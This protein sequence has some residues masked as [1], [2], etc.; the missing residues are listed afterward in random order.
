MPGLGME[1]R[2]AA[3]L[4]GKRRAAA[5]TSCPGLGSGQTRFWSAG[6]VD[7]AA[8]LGERS[9]TIESAALTCDQLATLILRH[10]AGANGAIGLA[11][12][13]R[14][15]ETG[16]SGDHKLAQFLIECEKRNWIIWG[17]KHRR[18]LGFVDLLIFTG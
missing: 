16:Y 9:L 15:F 3:V 10:G 17:G 18:S 2:G 12:I 7:V 4:V 14:D 13:S 6:L 8:R 5:Q 11:T 1:R